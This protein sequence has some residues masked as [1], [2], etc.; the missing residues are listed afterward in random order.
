MTD[1]SSGRETHAQELE[2]VSRV[3]AGA[4]KELLGRPGITG[5]DIG[6]KE[7]GGRISADLA[8]RV[9]VEHKRDDVPEEERVPPQ[10]D[11]VP[12]DV[13]ERTFDLHVLSV[14]ATSA[15]LDADRQW[16]PVLTGGI[17][18]GPCRVVRGQVHGGTLGAVVKDRASGHAM[19]LANFHVMCVD[20]TWSEGDQIAQPA[21][22]DAAQGIASVAATVRR[23][24]L[25]NEVDAALAELSGRSADSAIAEIGVVRGARAAALGETVA[26]RGRTTRLTF[27]VVDSLHLTVSLDYG[28]GIGQVTLRN[29][30]GVRA[31]LSRNT[32][33]AAAGDSGALLMGLGGEAL[34]LHVAGDQS[35]YGVANPIESVLDALDVDFWNTDVQ[36]P[37]RPQPPVWGGMAGP[38]PWGPFGVPFFPW[39]PWTG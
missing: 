19:L 5:V 17:S 11:G 3:K 13:I 27:G 16:Y 9:L 34:G 38:S 6:F 32:L 1:S 28:Q 24:S 7:V 8:I 23:A 4:E 35:G 14:A 21:R 39:M 2:A 25:G 22:L 26:K 30:I 36:Q 18:I 37:P 33:F 10:I 15:R 31:D 29:Q 20:P 12:T